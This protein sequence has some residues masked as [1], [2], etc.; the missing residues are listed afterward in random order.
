MKGRLGADDDQ[1]ECARDDKFEPKGICGE[2]REW[3]YEKWVCV[4]R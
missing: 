2:H 4:G 1:C 3:D